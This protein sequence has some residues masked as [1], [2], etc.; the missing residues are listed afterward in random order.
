[1]KLTSI[2][3]LLP[4]CALTAA[5]LPAGPNCPSRTVTPSEQLTIFKSFVRKFYVEKN[6]PAAF[7]DH[8]AESYI[9]HNP[10][11]LSGR[12]VASD[13]L[14]KYLPA[15]NIT[16][17]KIALFDNHGW[18]LVKQTKEGEGEKGYTA[19]VDVF[20]MEGSC[21]VEHWDVIQQRAR[22]ASFVNPLAIFDGQNYT[23]AV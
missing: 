10:N 2:S 16:V 14:S 4:L 18:V 6:V 20:R 13:G 23:N 7:T 19:V 12:Q 21:V 15:L 22:N 8:V 11:F 3:S 17:T 5:Q 9:Q 1:M